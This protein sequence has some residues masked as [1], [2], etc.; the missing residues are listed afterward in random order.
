MPAPN[1][2][3]RQIKFSMFWMYAIILLFLAGICYLDD[4]SIEKEVSYT[5]FENIVAP[6]DS[7]HANLSGITKLV[8]DTKKGRAT[9][10]L[11]DSLAA[12]N[13]HANQF[14]P[15]KGQEAKIWT[16]SAMSASSSAK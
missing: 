15:G 4:N 6:E 14:T 1:P 10:Y 2:K 11:S 12:A 16:K 13:F 7:T 5:E 3:K 9:A 8:I